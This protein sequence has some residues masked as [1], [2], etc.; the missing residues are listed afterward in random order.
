MYHNIEYEG[1]VY[2]CRK[3]VVTED[4][5]GWPVGTPV[6]FHAETER[7]YNLEAT[8]YWYHG[9]TEFTEQ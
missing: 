4:E 6:W 8:D 7:A 2:C 5:E 9:I 1:K 3:G